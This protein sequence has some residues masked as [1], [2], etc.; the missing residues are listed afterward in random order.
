MNV[1]VDMFVV[2]SCCSFLQQN[3]EE[4]DTV[5]NHSAVR[6]IDVCV[7]LSGSKMTISPDGFSYTESHSTNILPPLQH[8]SIRPDQ[9]LQVVSSSLSDRFDISSDAES[10]NL[11]SSH[12]ASSGDS[13]EHAFLVLENSR[14]NATY[15][16]REL[17]GDPDEN[18]ILLPTVTEQCHPKPSLL[19]ATRNTINRPTIS[20]NGHGLDVSESVLSVLPQ[21]TAMASS[22][23]PSVHADERING[24]SENENILPKIG[25]NFVGRTDCDVGVLGCCEVVSSTSED[26][27]SEAGDRI[28]STGVRSVDPSS[29]RSSLSRYS[30]SYNGT[31]PSYV[32]SGDRTN[33]TPTSDPDDEGVYL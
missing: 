4:G 18:Y 31:E 3:D 23:L 12:T 28:L 10:D 24:Y 33:V 2:E 6:S 26:G 16:G 9:R 32:A 25:A 22:I 11:T 21:M 14:I 13:K 20:A 29:F 5:S 7:S 17:V 30:S 27:S 8:C 19:T 15:V 1:M